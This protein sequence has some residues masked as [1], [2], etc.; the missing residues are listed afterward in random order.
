MLSE[1][2]LVARSSTELIDCGLNT[3]STKC[4]KSIAAWKCKMEHVKTI[5]VPDKKSNYRGKED[6]GSFALGMPWR[7]EEPERLPENLKLITQNK[8]EQQRE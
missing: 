7:G 8:R 3:K 1:T 6:E 5:S 2:K 4:S